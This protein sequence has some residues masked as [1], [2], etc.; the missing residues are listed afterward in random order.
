MVAVFVHY[1]IIYD[2]R[3]LKDPEIIIKMKNMWQ[4]T[5]GPLYKWFSSLGVETLFFMFVN[6]IRQDLVG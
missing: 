5:D 4:K 6:N 3:H 2:K 1:L